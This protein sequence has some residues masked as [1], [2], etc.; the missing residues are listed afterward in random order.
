MPSK[1]ETSNSRP[2]QAAIFIAFVTTCFAH[3]LI[4]FAV[5]WILHDRVGAIGWRLQWNDAAM[6][7]ALVTVWRVWFR[8][9]D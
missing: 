8:R 7:G 1:N 6:L 2:R 9:R 5:A 4:L 3:A